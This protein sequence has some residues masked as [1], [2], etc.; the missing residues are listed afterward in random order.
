MPMTP[1]LCLPCSTTQV[2]GHC[3]PKQNGC[4][5]GHVEQTHEQT[6]HIY[7]PPICP[8]PRAHGSHDLKLRAQ[9]R[10]RGHAAALGKPRLLQEVP[11]LCQRHSMH[12]DASQDP[13]IRLTCLGVPLLPGPGP[14]SNSRSFL[15][16]AWPLL[17]QDFPDVQ[18]NSSRRSRARGRGG[19]KKDLGLRAESSQTPH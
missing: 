5:V 13:L 18:P 12:A 11:M 19:A 10:P 7:G 8:E 17:G 1:F 4:L 9:R 15:R 2:S 14:N 16:R 6:H 3:N